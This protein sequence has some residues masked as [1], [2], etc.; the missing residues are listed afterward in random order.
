MRE[1]PPDIS[2]PFSPAT[3]TNNPIPFGTL[4]PPPASLPPRTSVSEKTKH[5]P[6]SVHLTKSEKSS[7]IAPWTQS[8]IIRV[9]GLKISKEGM[10]D[11]IMRI[12]K[13]KSLP[14]ILPLGKGFFLIKFAAIEDRWKAIL[15]GPTFVNGH[16]MTLH[17]WQPHFNPENS[18]LSAPSP[19][20][21]KLQSLPI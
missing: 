14:I 12:W 9:V 7:I 8:V 17:L 1:P 4:P 15:N 11:K 20:W 21:V 3:T 6:C 10:L 13:L 5:T 16:L 2:F 19:V 18:L